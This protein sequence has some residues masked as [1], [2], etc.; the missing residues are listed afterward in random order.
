MGNKCVR[1]LTRM[2]EGTG[3]K[4]EEEEGVALEG[5][6]QAGSVVDN[7][8]DEPLG[9]GYGEL[10][11]RELALEEGSVPSKFEV[12]QRS[13][14]VPEH[15]GAESISAFRQ[16]TLVTWVDPEDGRV[17]TDILTYVPPAAPVQT[18]PSFEW[19][20][21]YD[22]T[23]CLDTLPPTLFEGYDQDLRE[24]YIRLGAVRDEIFLQR[25][26]FRSLEREQ[27]RA[28][29]TFSA[30][31]RPVLALE[32]WAGGAKI[33]SK[34][35]LKSGFHQVS[36]DEESIPW[37]AFL[38]PGGLYEWLVMPFGL[39]NAPAV[40]QRKMDKCFKGTESFIAVYIDDIL[41]FSKNEKEHAKHLEK[42]LKIYED[43]GLVLS[44]TKMKIACF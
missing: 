33:F 42:M 4:E 38:V 22:H 13:R 31:W 10:R 28:T 17:Y 1:G 5:Q 19:S 6:Q 23:Q 37:T 15:E 12:G 40:F 2:E 25:Y 26:R 34:F 43:N 32:A 41:V 8:V 11:H 27:E 9:L 36:M 30:I 24:L 39:K 3:I 18:P 7:A 35:D 16:P 29:V 44:P 21:L 20:I 14:S